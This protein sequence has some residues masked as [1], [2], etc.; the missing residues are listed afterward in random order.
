MRWEE[1]KSPNFDD[2]P[3]DEPPNLVVVHG[4]SL[5][6]GEY[7]GSAIADLFGNCLDAGAHPYFKE[8]AHL[9]VSAHFLIRRDG[10]VL[11]F[12]HPAKRA[13]H[14]GVSTWRGRECCN[15]YSIGIELEGCD[16]EAYEPAQ[17]ERLGD[18]IQDLCG[19][20]PIQAVVGH[21]DIAPG[22]KTDPGP[23]FRWSELQR[24]LKH[25]GNVAIGPEGA[26]R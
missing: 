2:R 10:T 7:G 26:A 6:P 20:Y 15:D 8:I 23:Y 24:I 9:R 21:S 16:W 18:L 5:P 17:Y 3:N 25:L 14:A 22:R 4:I 12:V 11:N 13:W 19:E 1:Y